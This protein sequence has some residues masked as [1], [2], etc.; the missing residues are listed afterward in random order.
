MLSP[1]K[2]LIRKSKMSNSAAR[3]SWLI[4]AT[5]LDRVGC[6]YPVD[7]YLI[8][9]CIRDSSISLEKGF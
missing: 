3:D 7:T 9:Q 8:T 4:L 2:K 5:A 6:I 1:N